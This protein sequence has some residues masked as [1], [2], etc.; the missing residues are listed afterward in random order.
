MLLLKSYTP[1]WQKWLPRAIS[2]LRRLV[3]LLAFSFFP[4]LSHFS[5]FSHSSTFQ[6]YFSLFSLFSNCFYAL[7][8]PTTTLRLL[9]SFSMSFLILNFNSFFFRSQNSFSFNSNFFHSSFLSLSSPFIQPPLC[10]CMF[11]GKGDETV[12]GRERYGGKVEKA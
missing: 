6:P 11:N 12:E 7:I 1:G 5:Y 8:S 4:L 10:F 3:N 9:F 2:L